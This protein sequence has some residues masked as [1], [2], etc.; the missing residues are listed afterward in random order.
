MTSSLPGGRSRAS[1]PR[2]APAASHW[3]WQAG[4]LPERPV[5]PASSLTL[6]LGCSIDRVELLVCILE[7]LER[8]YELWLAAPSV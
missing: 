3:E 4:D 8:H 6:E 7:Q 1:W 2:Q 5:F